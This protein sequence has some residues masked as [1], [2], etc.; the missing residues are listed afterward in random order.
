MQKVSGWPNFFI[1]SSKSNSWISNQFHYRNQ[2]LPAGRFS[3]LF[4]KWFTTKSKSNCGM[5][6]FHWYLLSYLWFATEK[7]SQTQISSSWTQI[8]SSSSRH[9]IS[10]APNPTCRSFWLRLHCNICK[11]RLLHNLYMRN[12]NRNFKLQF[13]PL[14]SFGS[15][16]SH[17]KLVGLRPHSPAFDFF[18]NFHFLIENSHKL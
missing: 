17:P 11:T 18:N 6:I 14:K 3:R 9:S 7:A 5:Y 13:H 15:R 10:L 4:H 2:T 12:W 1:T 16:S 8:S